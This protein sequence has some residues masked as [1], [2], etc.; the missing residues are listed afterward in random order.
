MLYLLPTFAWLKNLVQEVSLRV[1]FFLGVLVVI[2]SMP[3]AAVEAASVKLGWNPSPAPLVVAYNIYYGTA[4][5]TYPDKISFGAAT[6][7]PIM[8]LVEGTTYYFV[9]TAYD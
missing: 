3:F 4:S 1:V 7:A 6:S 9:A 2:I 5:H 8:N